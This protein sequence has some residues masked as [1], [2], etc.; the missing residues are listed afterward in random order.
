M[1]RRNR[2]RQGAENPGPEPT[3]PHRS[4]IPGSLDHISGDA[5]EFE[6]SIV[7]GGEGEPVDEDVVSE[8][9]LEQEAQAAL[10]R[11]ETAVRARQAA[12]APTAGRGGNRVINFI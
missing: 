1:G 11:P 5:E 9:E 7:A 12:G 3:E 6:A 10:G 8:A 2:R 4:N